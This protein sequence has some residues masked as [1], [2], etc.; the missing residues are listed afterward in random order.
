VHW[1]SIVENLG[2]VRYVIT[3][4]PYYGLRTYRPDQWLREWFLGGTETV[5]YTAD[6]QIAHTS[7]DDFA[8]DLGRVW[9]RIGK[10]A[11]P[12]ARMIIRF[13]AINDRPV[14]PASIIRDSM[15][16]TPWRVAYTRKAGVSSIGKRQADWFSANIHPPIE[17][18]DVYCHLA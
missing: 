2:K 17:E 5:C 14:E 18:V 15:E 3:S 16:G 1:P 4:P 10:H 6:K 11:A 9:R 7:P 8:A 12:D 13:G